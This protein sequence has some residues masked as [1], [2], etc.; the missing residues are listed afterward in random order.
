MTDLMAQ[1]PARLHQG[2]NLLRLASALVA[3]A[4]L[5]GPTAR[6]GAIG[7]SQVATFPHHQGPLCPG[8]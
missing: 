3:I 5:R 1:C 7:P 8:P 6:G 4:N 2:P